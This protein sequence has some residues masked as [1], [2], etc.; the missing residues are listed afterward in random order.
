MSADTNQ[1]MSQKRARPPQQDGVLVLDKP[2]GPTSTACL[3]RIKR[4]LGQ[5]KIGHAGTLDPLAN[6][7]L[8][9]LLG[10][11]T[12]LAPYLTEGEKVY[13]GSLELGTATDTYDSQGEVVST[14]DWSHISEAEARAAVLAWLDDTIQIVPPYSAAKHKGKALYALSREGKEVPEK[15]KEIRISG[16]EVV[17]IDLPRIDFRVRCGAGTYIRSLVHSL[18]MRLGC[19]AYMTAL[20]RE[21]SHPFDLAEAHSLDDVLGEPEALAGRVL[22]LDRSLPHW[23]RHTLSERDAALVKN[24]AQLE[25]GAEGDEADDQGRIMFLSPQGEALAL[26]QKAERGGATVWALLRGLWRS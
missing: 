15:R 1:N 26:A 5:K 24:G 3:E 14:A 7:V 8:V 22:S 16:A 11:A 21:H 10:Q 12:K 2:S 9:V 20:T 25:C 23:P 19:G 13:K 6:G 4:T 18:G 17:S